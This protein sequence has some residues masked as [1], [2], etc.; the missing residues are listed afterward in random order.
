MTPSPVY[1]AGTVGCFVPNDLVRP[2]VGAAHGP[3]AGRVAA[4]KDL[5]DI[6]GEKT[7]G[8]SPE[9]LETAKP[10]ARHSAVVEKLLAAGATIA[11][12]TIADEF[13]F[14][15]TGT[16]SRYTIPVNVRA[17]GRVPGGSSSGSAAAMAAGLCDFAMG[18][19]TGGS[20]RIP[21]SFCGVFGIRPTHGRVDLTGG[22]AMAPSLDTGGW[23]T[24]DAGLFATIGDVLLDHRKVGGRIAHVSIAADAFALADP[25]VRGAHEGFLARAAD[26][27]PRTSDI[28]L[29]SD[30]YADWRAAFRN[31]QAH[32][33]MALYGAW[34]AQRRPAFNPSVG[35][36]FR[37][38]TAVTDAMKAEADAM[39]ARV[40]AHIHG[41]V[42]PGSV[43]CLPTAPT[44]A[45]LRDASEA[46]LESFRMATLALTCPAGLA[47]LPQVTLP[48]VRVDGCPAGLS[49]IG[50]AGGDEALLG[51]ARRLAPLCAH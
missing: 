15:L 32:E 40:R 11:H 29:A 42:P 14:S 48:A 3:L 50:W 19:D 27:L 5:Y 43:V 1:E 33:V 17:P 7:G 12:R 34:A 39:R 51:L 46:E 37:Y 6:A 35:D 21:A 49:F 23:F 4:V 44:I 22:M 8:G 28:T 30:G 13:F 31:V 36:R 9:W 26:L 10:A 41:L 47:G 2:I 45:P 20:V 38:A 18:S 24:D 16:H 25:A